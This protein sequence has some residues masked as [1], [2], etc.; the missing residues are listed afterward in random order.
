MDA[1]PVD[2]VA[3]RRLVDDLQRAATPAHVLPEAHTG[4]HSPHDVCSER[5]LIRNRASKPRDRHEHACRTSVGVQAHRVRAVALKRPRGDPSGSQGG[6]R[7]PRAVADVRSV[8]EDGGVDRDDAV[9]PD[10]I[11]GELHGANGLRDRT[12]RGRRPGGQPLDARIPV[13]R[14][15][16]RCGSRRGLVGVQEHPQTGD[17]RRHTVDRLERVPLP[18]PSRLNIQRGASFRAGLPETCSRGGASHR[19]SARES[20]G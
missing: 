8:F 2:A 14:L 19:A 4:T 17:V 11:G 1:H 16:I 6:S 18:A 3:V 9:D 12:D 10:G 7:D 5:Q 15:S 13:L 20:R